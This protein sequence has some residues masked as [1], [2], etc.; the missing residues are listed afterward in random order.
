[1]VPI[2]VFLAEQLNRKEKN[3]HVRPTPPRRLVVMEDIIQ[4]DEKYCIE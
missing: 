2:L 3:E 4:N 1:M